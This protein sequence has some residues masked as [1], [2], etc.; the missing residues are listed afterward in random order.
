M[1]YCRTGA[2]GSDVYMYTDGVIWHVHGPDGYEEHSNLEDARQHL[3]RIREQGHNVPDHAI[4]RVE[5]ELADPLNAPREY[6]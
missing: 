2:D 3:L 4:E 5:K 1:S 6:L